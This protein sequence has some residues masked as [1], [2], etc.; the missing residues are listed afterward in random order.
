MKTS[1]LDFILCGI[2]TAIIFFCSFVVDLFIVAPT[3]KPFVG[4]YHVIIEFFTFL[5]FYGVFSGILVQIFLKIKPLQVGEFSMDHPNFTYWKLLT[6]ITS[7]GEFSLLPFTTVFTK[8]IILKIFGAKIGKNVAI[9]GT[10]D[11]PFLI[12]IGD[13]TIIG[14]DSLISGNAT[15]N[16]KIIIGNV[17]IG[18]NVTIGTNS[19]VLPNTEIGNNS[20]VSIGSVIL[21]GTKVPTTETWRGNP[22]R[23]WHATVLTSEPISN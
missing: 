11:D 13:N 21:S 2:F 7:L 23:K 18:N 5:L 15:M 19:V 16:G 4:D 1:L 20:N 14:H 3:I 8:P 10:V 17:F 22:A 6:I 9:G 12:T